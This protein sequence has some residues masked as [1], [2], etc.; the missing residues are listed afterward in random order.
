MDAQRKEALAMIQAVYNDGEAEIN[1]RVYKFLGTTHIKRRRVFAFFTSVQ[2]QI[3]TGNFLFL[4]S[5]EFKSVEAAMNDMI[6]FEDSLLS[7]I[8]GHWEDYPEDYMTLISTAMGVISYPFL[9]GS[10]TV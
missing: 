9:R 10:L 4:D 3:K 5:P 2:D 6:T 8:K 7:K 1:G